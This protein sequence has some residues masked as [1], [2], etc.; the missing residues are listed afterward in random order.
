MISASYICHSG[1]DLLVVNAARVSFAKRSESLTE[2]DRKLI[3]YLARHNHWAPFSH[4]QITMHCKAPIFVR[5]QCFKHKVGFAESEISRRYVDD[6]PKVFMP[7]TW[8]SRAASAKQGSGDA[9]PDQEK[10]RYQASLAMHLAVSGYHAL[11]DMGV[12][13]EQARMVL[14]Q[15]AITEW[16]WTGSLAAW[17]RF[18][19]QRTHDHA[20]S[21][22]ADLARQCAEIIQPLFPVSWPVLTGATP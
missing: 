18:Y 5:T 10:V 17:A 21:E 20:Q 12:A 13:P 11:L 4:P 1:D 6:P 8:R 15:A 22:T 9:L 19:C 7:Q 16:V 2:A 14:P 3:G